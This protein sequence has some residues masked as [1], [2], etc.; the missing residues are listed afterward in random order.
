MAQISLSVS[1]ENDSTIEVSPVENEGDCMGIHLHTKI[2]TFGSP[3]T[4]SKDWVTIHGTR[5]DMRKLAT[6]MLY[7]LPAPDAELA[8]PLPPVEVV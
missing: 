7:A 3:F 8:E 4:Y 5:A 6:A 2:K 1:T